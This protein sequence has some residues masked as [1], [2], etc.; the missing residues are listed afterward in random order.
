[1]IQVVQRMK[2]AIYCPDEY[3]VRQGT[4]PKVRA[5]KYVQASKYVRTGE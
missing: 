4:T 2:S 1:M 3:I 5:S